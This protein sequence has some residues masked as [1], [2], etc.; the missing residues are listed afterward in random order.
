MEKPRKGAKYTKRKA[1]GQKDINGAKFF[2]FNPCSSVLIRG[3]ILVPVFVC[4][5]LRPPVP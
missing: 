1:T 2:A 3:Q 4:V 5:H